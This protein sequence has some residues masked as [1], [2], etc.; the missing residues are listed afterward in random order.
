MVRQPDGQYV[1]GGSF[2]SINGVRA[3]N[4][5]R[6]HADGTLDAAFTA[7]SQAN[8]PVQSLALQADG[9]I[10]AGG[11][12]DSLAGEPRRAVGRLQASGALDAAF[13]AGLPPASPYPLV[14]GQ[15][16][17][18][19]GGGEAGY[20]FGVLWQLFGTTNQLTAGLAL[21][22]IA[23]WVTR[24]GRNPTAVLVPLVFLLVMTSWALVV[25][26][27]KF[28]EEGQWV[29][30]P[31]HALIFVLA[32]WLIVEAGLALRSAF[33]DRDAAGP[34]LRERGDAPASAV[35]RGN[36]SSPADD[37]PRGESSEDDVR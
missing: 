26:L 34:M 17:L 9:R 22:V 12:F 15:V 36:E 33:Q 1:V 6:L 3:R 31:L 2:S 24:S 23:V 37:R 10:V 18:L 28:V 16:A 25:N 20:T 11:Q 21:S 7:R 14:L 4:L 27:G 30:A 19:P 32:M 5:A 13:D 29:L 8:G 35:S